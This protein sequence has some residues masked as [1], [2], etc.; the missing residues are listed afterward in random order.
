M[1][2][3]KKNENRGRNMSDAKKTGWRLILTT[4]AILS[5]MAIPAAAQ[6]L[7]YDLGP[8][9]TVVTQDIRLW[10]SPCCGSGGGTLRWRLRQW[11]P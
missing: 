2:D 1:S 11:T 3:A 5:V 10:M 9:V 7:I 6:Y 4:L 8:D